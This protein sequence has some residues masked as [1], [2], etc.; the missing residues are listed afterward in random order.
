[1][2]F[3]PLHPERTWL[4]PRTQEAS[5]RALRIVKGQ[6]GTGRASA[7][8]IAALFLDFVLRQAE[9]G[10]GAAGFGPSRVAACRASAAEID[11]PIRTDASPG[12][13]GRGDF[14]KRTPIAIAGLLAAMALPATAVAHIERPS[15]WPNPAPDTSVTPPAG[16]KVPKA[17]SLGSALDR[18]RRGQT[19]VVCKKHSMA[20]LRK[21]V[22]R[23][24]KHGYDI[25][26]HDHR[27]LSA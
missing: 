10:P 8:T 27:S 13:N 24:R 15:Y 17:R 5:R 11:W 7:R 6:P 1:M 19:R 26:P 20:R 2:S 14:L 12:S 25:R 9:R 21:S 22:H 4:P 3:R 18:G 23:A 16:G